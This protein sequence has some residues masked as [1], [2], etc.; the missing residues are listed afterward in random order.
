MLT[1]EGFNTQYTYKPRL[2]YFVLFVDILPPFLHFLKIIAVLLR[3]LFLA[4]QVAFQVAFQ[5]TFFLNTCLLTC[6]FQLVLFPSCLLEL[7]ELGQAPAGT[8]KIGGRLLRRIMAMYRDD[9]V[10]SSSLVL[11]EELSQRLYDADSE[12]SASFRFPTD[13]ASVNRV[14]LQKTLVFPT[15]VY[16]IYH[17]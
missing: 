9:A 15:T 2:Q 16:C 7:I 14:S 17:L 11:A 3:F 10:A 13:A 5:L 6:F 12:R 8:L 1:S 4:F